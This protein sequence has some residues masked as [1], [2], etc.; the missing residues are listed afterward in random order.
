MLTGAANLAMSSR[1]EA[2]SSAGP[3]EVVRRLSSGQR[4]LALD[5][6]AGSGSDVEALVDD[7]ARVIHATAEQIPA[8]EERFAIGVAQL[9]GDVQSLRP[10]VD[11]LRMALVSDGVAILVWDAAALTGEAVIDVVGVV[12]GSF[13]TSYVLADLTLW[14]SQAAPSLPELI[15]TSG[16]SFMAIGSDATWRL[17]AVTDASGPAEEMKPIFQL[18]EEQ[19]IHLDGQRSLLASFEARLGLQAQQLAEARSSAQVRDVEVADLQGLVADLQGLVA[20]LQGRVADL[21]GRVAELQENLASA[22][23]GRHAAER[24]NTALTTEVSLWESRYAAVVGSVGWRMVE[25]LRKL[26]RP[27]R[28]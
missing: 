23:A 1:S 15:D 6:T 7:T 9:G 10:I 20:D 27:F 22:L 28:H 17:L 5:V 3:W 21:Q 8:M 11:T 12:Q 13:D 4:V 16:G 25:R 18:V 24:A 2:P 19:A 26:S 14:V